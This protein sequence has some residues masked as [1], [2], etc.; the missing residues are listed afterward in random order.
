LLLPFNFFYL[1]EELVLSQ[2]LPFEVRDFVEVL[3]YSNVVKVSVVSF[4]EAS[5]WD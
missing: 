5:N 1:L 4:D 2:L 3:H